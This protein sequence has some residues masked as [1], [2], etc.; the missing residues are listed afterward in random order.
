MSLKQLRAGELAALLGAAL[1]LISTFVASYDG[2]LGSL[3][4]WDTFGPAV[5]LELVA[6][7]A[8]LAM[9]IAA[10]TERTPALPV[11]SMVWCF[12]LGLV[13]IIAAIVRLVDLPDHATSLAVGAWLA[14][15]AALA[16]FGGAWEALRDERTPLYEQVRPQPRPRP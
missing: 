10:A 7:C 4:A 8:A 9:V 11:A 13:A 14:L 16:I 2:P 15:A 12:V 6:L 3:T 5:T 1:M